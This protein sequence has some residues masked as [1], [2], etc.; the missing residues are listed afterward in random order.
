MPDLKQLAKIAINR[1]LW[2][3]NLQWRI[4]KAVDLDESGVYFI[5]WITLDQAR[6]L[7]EMLPVQ[8]GL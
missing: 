1:G 7:L 4:D 2:R 3:H 5:E 6:E 8:G